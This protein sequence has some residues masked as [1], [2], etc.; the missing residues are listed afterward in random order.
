MGY[1]IVAYLNIDQ[2]AVDAFI[3][4]HSLD[5]NDWSPCKTIAEHFYGNIIFF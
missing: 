5:I 2:E 3:K 1:E 4:E